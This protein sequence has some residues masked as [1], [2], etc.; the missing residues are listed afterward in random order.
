VRGGRSS[1]ARPE[2]L[3]PEPVDGRDD[4]GPIEEVVELL[5][6]RLG[7]QQAAVAGGPVE[8]PTLVLVLRPMLGAD[9]VVRAEAAEA[10]RRW[11]VAADPATGLDQAAEGPFRVRRARVEQDAEVG[12]LGVDPLAD[13]DPPA[14]AGGRRDAPEAR[15]RTGAG[16]DADEPDGLEG[17]DPDRRGP[18]RGRA[19]AG[20]L[21]LKQA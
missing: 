7:D 15:R 19:G 8:E 10:E 2:E 20:P 6:G 3:R 4:Q 17:P 13:R 5:A 11:E 21:A 12:R 16:D 1:V 9:R 18:G 14:V